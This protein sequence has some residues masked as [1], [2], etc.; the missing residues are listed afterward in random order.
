MKLD[1]LGTFDEMV[2]LASERALAED[3]MVVIHRGGCDGED[4][5]CQPKVIRPY[6]PVDEPRAA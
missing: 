2:T 3:G 5:L 1:D 4:C 6:E